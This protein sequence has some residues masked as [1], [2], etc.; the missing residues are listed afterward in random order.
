MRN[1]FCYRLLGTRGF[2]TGSPI[3]TFFPAPKK[4]SNFGLEF[5]C[6]TVKIARMTSL[7]SM[8]P[9]L[10]ASSSRFK[11]AASAVIACTF[12]L[13]S[14]SSAQEA[15]TDPVGVVTVNVAAGTGTAKARSLISLPLFETE[16]ITGLRTGRIT[17]VTASTIS[18]SVAEW[19]PG[20]LSQL[21]SPYLL[22]ITSGAAEGLTLLISTQVQ[23]TSTTVTIDSGEASL[24]DLTTLGIATG[25]NGDSFE[26]IP[27]DTLLS[28]FGNPNSSGI[29]GGANAN[30]ADVV[31]I[32]AGDGS[33]ANYYYN[34]T[35]NRWA[36]QALGNPDANN[37]PLRPDNGITFMRL[38][39]TPLTFLAT[40]TVPKTNR[41]VAVRNSGVMNLAAYW[42]VTR[43]LSQ[44][45]L[46]TIP[47]WISASQATTADTVIVGSSTYFFDGT[48]WRR[49][50]LGSPISNPTIEP[51]QS[52]LINK[53]GTLSG[54]SYLTQIRPYNLQP[55]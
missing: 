26:I 10:R 8:T 39:A 46:Q 6:E 50:A 12:A 55:Q 18:S 35:L 1:F 11:C 24:I 16:Q 25:E 38:G 48:N 51:G 34:T 9:S 15:V 29:L 47:G 7:L 31:S 3:L 32:T 30:V 28:F 54:V 40:G 14:L 2:A 22:R 4:D 5:R 44:I 41:K 36:R 52:V 45:G 19:E 13:P 33:F 17:S 43:T 27:C 42:P 21:V 53:R 49:Q 23:N 37:V 20:Q